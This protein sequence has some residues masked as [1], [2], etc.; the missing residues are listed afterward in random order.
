MPLFIA[1]S[2][3]V[4]YDV[5][6][7]LGAY[8]SESIA[9]TLKEEG[10]EIAPPTVPIVMGPTLSESDLLLQSTLD[11][12]KELSNDPENEA[13]VILA[14]GDHGIPGPWNTL[15]KRA[16]FYACG[17]TGI[18]YADWGF[19]EVGQSY[20]S[21]GIPVIAKAA[22]QRERVLVVGIY[23][24]MG[25]KRMHD[26]FMADHKNVA[27]MFGANMLD[28]KE[29]VFSQRGFLPDPHVA[30]WLVKTAHEVLKGRF[31]L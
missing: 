25:V 27:R 3:H 18:T 20:A 8:M 24:S 15:A 16:A 17:K 22:E 26:R 7:V 19:V 28:E 5:P 29:I 30:E 31:S 2:S 14:H 4:V 10:A 21:D 13:L 6:A 12:V 23:V 11:R 9:K 1:H